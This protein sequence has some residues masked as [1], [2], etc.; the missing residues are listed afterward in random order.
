MPVEEYKFEAETQNCKLNDAGL[1]NKNME[2]TELLRH[3]RLTPSNLKLEEVN[4]NMLIQ[5]PWDFLSDPSLDTSLELANSLNIPDR[6]RQIIPV[7]STSKF[8]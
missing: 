1:L 2:L 6:L 4:T 8:K 3:P 7:T 5:E